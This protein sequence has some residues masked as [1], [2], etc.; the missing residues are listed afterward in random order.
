[1]MYKPES[2]FYFENPS[3]LLNSRLCSEIFALTGEAIIEV[4]WVNASIHSPL[5][6]LLVLILRLVLYAV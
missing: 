2:V 3:C 1:M 5:S 4:H 6:D